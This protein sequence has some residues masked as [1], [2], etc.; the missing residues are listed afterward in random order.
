MYRRILKIGGIVTAAFA[1]IAWEQSI[2]ASPY[3]GTYSRQYLSTGVRSNGRSIKWNTTGVNEI[4]NNI[5]IEFF[6][7]TADCTSNSPNG[8]KLYPDYVVISLPDNGVFAYND[9]DGPLPNVSEEVEVQVNSGSVVAET[10]YQ[11]D[12]VWRCNSRNQS[13]EIN[14][15]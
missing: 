12:V 5:W 1:L 4:K 15:T 13:G 9:C 6:D 11:Y 14:I 8:D 10:A 3:T 7:Q 2:P